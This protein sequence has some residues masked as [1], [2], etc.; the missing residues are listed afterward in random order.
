MQSFFK[1]MNEVENEDLIFTLETIV[2]KCGEEM[3]PYALGLCQ[4]LVSMPCGQRGYG[5]RTFLA[6]VVLVNTLL[7]ST[8]CVAH[9]NHRARGS[10]S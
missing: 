2:D 4:N 7:M 1:L 5:E 10:I 6:F 8:C 3:A 9:S